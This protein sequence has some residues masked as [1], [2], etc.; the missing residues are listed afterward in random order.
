MFVVGWKARFDGREEDSN[1]EVYNMEV[2]GD[3]NVGDLITNVEL[4]LRMG[5]VFGAAFSPD[6]RAYF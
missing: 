5:K 4:D 1:F 3:R 6:S 2:A